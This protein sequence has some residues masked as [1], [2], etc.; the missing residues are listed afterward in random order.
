MGQWEV[1]VDRDFFFVQLALESQDV[2]DPLPISAPLR[3]FSSALPSFLL[4]FCTH[5]RKA[6]LIALTISPHLDS[7]FPKDYQLII[8]EITES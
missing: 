2:S 8:S 7:S 1:A 5:I 4:S 6:S 3:S